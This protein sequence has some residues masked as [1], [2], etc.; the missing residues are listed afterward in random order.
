MMSGFL[1]LPSLSKMMRQHFRFDAVFHF[2]RRGYAL[3]QL[4]PSRPQ[5]CRIRR[6][7]NQRMLEDVIGT[8][9]SASPKYQFRTDELIER[10][11]E[12][13]FGQLRNGYHEFV[14]EFP[15]YGGTELSDFLGRA[16]PIEPCQQRPM[17]AGWNCQRR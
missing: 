7:L 13:C 12:L 16:K 5:Q 11:A 10:F 17:Q 15:T 14:R 9:G 1:R 3:V 2:E 4:L 6:I 8:W